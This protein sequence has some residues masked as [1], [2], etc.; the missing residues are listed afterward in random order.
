VDIDTSHP[1]LVTGATGYLAGWIIKGLLDGGATVHATVRDPDATAR[2]QHLL[3]MADGSPGTLRFFRADLLDEGSYAEPMSGCRVVLHTAS[4]FKNV[5][6]DPQKELVDPA[7]LGT[8]TVLETADATPSVTRVVLT[9]SC[10]AIYGDAADCADAPGGRLTESVWNTTSSLEHQPY[11]YSKTLAE[12]EA[13]RIADA[14]DRWRLVAIN[15]SLIIGPSSGPQP[16]SDSFAIVKQLGDG[17]MRMGAP[18]LGMGI[19][20]VRDVAR[21]HLAAAFLPDASG[22]NI[23]SGHETTI[24]ELGQALRPRFGDRLPLPN[25]ALPKW[26]VWLVAPAVGQ[27]RHFVARNVDHPWHA[28]T[29][30]SQ[31]ELG[32]TYR[33]MTETIEEMAEQ[34]LAAGA[35]TK[36]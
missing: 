22:R 21:A 7:V 25:R 34:M 12:R 24:L 4:P 30:K 2:L 36:G 31:R 26:L 9:S 32:M 10:V 3:D 35:F 14:Q 18:R 5:V 28:D 16:T 20:D 33:P 6:Q 17:T 11:S 1:V 15:P 13:W 8:R 27:S 19:V 23:V 29:S